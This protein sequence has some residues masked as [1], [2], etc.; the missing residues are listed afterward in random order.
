MITGIFSEPFDRGGY[1]IKSL[2]K[3]LEYFYNYSLKGNNIFGG[4]MGGDTK[5]YEYSD[6]Y[7]YVNGHCYDETT[8]ETN[9]DGS[10]ESCSTWT[11]EWEECP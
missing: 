11:C 3:S 6:S 9:E 7:E 2:M 5:T 8:K 10:T 1:E 4:Q